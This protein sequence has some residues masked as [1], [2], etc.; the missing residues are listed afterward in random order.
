MPSSNS[1]LPRRAAL[2]AGGLLLAGLA[3]PALVRPRRAG[4][5][6]EIRLRS[7]A[8]GT[9]V[10]FDPIGVLIEPGQTGRKPPS[11]GT[12]AIWSSRVIISRSP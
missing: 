9:K 10:W 1:E 11:R 3:A 7:D 8:L 12:P 6:V 2:R 5:V 4:G